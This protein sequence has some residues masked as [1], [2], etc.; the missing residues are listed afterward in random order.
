MTTAKLFA[1]NFTTLAASPDGIAKLREL[2]LQLAVQGKL[3]PQN[4]KDEPADKLLEKIQIE[5]QKLIRAGKLQK[6][7][8]FPPIQEDEKFF[9]I[10]RNWAFSRLGNYTGVIMG[11]SPESKSYNESGEGLPF[12]QGKSEYGSLYPTPK[13]WCTEP[14]KIARKND[15]L[16]SVRAPVGPTNICPNTSCIGRGLAAIR[17]ISASEH[18]YLLYTLRAFEN[19]IASKGVGS[20][21]SAIG[22]KDLNNYIIPV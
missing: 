7:N 20:T 8:P 6:E 15:I 10:P 22:K 11:Q 14:K 18:F 13:K 21:F 5:K 9:A 4:P 12:Y 16:I 19:K 3:L 2:I 17:S 1:E